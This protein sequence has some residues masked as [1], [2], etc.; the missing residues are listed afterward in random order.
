MREQYYYANLPTKLIKENFKSKRDRNQ[1]LLAIT[2]ITSWVNTKTG[3]FYLS[4]SKLAEELECSRKRAKTIIDNL[5]RLGYIKKISD[6]PNQYG[7]SVYKLLTYNW[8]EKMETATETALETATETAPNKEYQHSEQI[9]E[10]A[11]ETALET[12]TAHQTKNNITNNE[13]TNNKNIENQKFECVNVDLN[14]KEI[15]EILTQIDEEG[16]APTVDEIEK[17]LNQLIGIYPKK[18]GNFRRLRERYLYLRLKK[19]LEFQEIYE[20]VQSYMLEMESQEIEQKYWKNLE[21]LLDPV[22]L[23][24]FL[25]KPVIAIDKKGQKF[26]G[27]FCTGTGVL[28]YNFEGKPVRQILKPHQIEQM[29]EEDRLIFLK[30]PEVVEHAA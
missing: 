19:E 14:N 15:E 21:N 22:E 4:I 9:T 5:I 6:A 3:I 27:E 25:F 30:E 17:E 13:I 1:H 29:I 2:I 28:R 26:V 20:A 18:N 8:T 10:T 11:T 7:Q 24:T 12:A 16:I 23:D